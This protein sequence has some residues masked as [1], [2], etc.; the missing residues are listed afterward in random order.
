VNEGKKGDE[1]DM[2]NLI[3]WV[4]LLSALILVSCESESRGVRDIV[5][6]PLD[7]TQ[8]P[9]GVYTG[10]ADYRESPYRVRVTVR[11]RKIA[12]IEL[13]ACQGNDY[14][15]EALAV[16]KRVISRQSLRV[17]AVSGAT[18]SSKLYLIAIHDALA[19]KTAPR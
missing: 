15:R 7:L 11:D 9:D 4:V 10:E 13:L 3:A 17:D 8:L 14:D 12:G 2:K 16:L 6:P 18:R 5:L 19:G 1:P